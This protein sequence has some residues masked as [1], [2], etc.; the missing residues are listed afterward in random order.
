MGPGLS[1]TSPNLQK[2]KFAEFISLLKNSYALTSAPDSG[3]KY[4]VFVVFQ[5]CISALL[6]CRRA[7][8]HFFNRL[9]PS[10]HSAE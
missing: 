9:M 7:D 3:A 2:A 10:T 4:T 6:G 8:D 5:P 1:G